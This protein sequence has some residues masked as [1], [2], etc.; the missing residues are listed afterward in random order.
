MRHYSVIPAARPSPPCVVGYNGQYF[1]QILQSFAMFLAPGLGKSFC[2]SMVGLAAIVRTHGE[3]KAVCIYPAWVSG[4]I[5]MPKSIWIVLALLF[6][7]IGAP[8]ASADTETIDFTG[9]VTCNDTTPCG[10][11]SSF[12]VTGTYQYNPITQTIGTFSF[13][14]PIGTIASSSSSC[15]FAGSFEGTFDLGFVDDTPA[16]C[17]AVE[18]N[19]LSIQLGFASGNTSGVGSLVVG[20]FA[21]SAC[22]LASNGG[23]PTLTPANY[24]PFTS[25]TAT[26]EVTP[27]VPEP[28]TIAL[29]LLG[30]GLVLATRKRIGQGLSRVS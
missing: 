22:L 10:G 15:T 14:T 5:R 20:L 4:G 9:V 1:A 18:S 26:A 7:A 19:A 2:F 27:A 17:L 8:N 24:F 30:I 13:V 6:V 23:C 11:S 12:T 3:P 21:S 25:G 29:T 16:G 28:G